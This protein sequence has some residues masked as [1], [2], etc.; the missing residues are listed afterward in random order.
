VPE[1]TG[2]V[3]AILRCIPATGNLGSHQ[4]A[5]SGLISTGLAVQSCKRFQEPA[6][7]EYDVLEALM[8]KPRTLGVQTKWQS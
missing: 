8:Q 2:V 7:G 3:A 1:H 4:P 5:K 6:I